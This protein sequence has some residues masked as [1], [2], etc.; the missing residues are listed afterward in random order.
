MQNYRVGYLDCNGEVAVVFIDSAGDCNP[1]RLMSYARIGEHSEAAVDWV[2]GQPLA[3]ESLYRELHDYL[4]R[5]YAEK[6]G[7]AVALVID[8]RAVPR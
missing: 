6:P 7:E 2:R 8:Q 3:E 1:G 4:R 5:R